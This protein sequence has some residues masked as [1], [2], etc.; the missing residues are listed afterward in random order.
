[1]S[2]NEGQSAFERLLGALDPD[3]ERAGKL[4]ERL[5]EKLATFFDWRGTSS[6]EDLA[7]KTIDRTGRKIEA[8]EVIRSADV[9]RYAYG[10]A[11]NIFRENWNEKKREVVSLRRLP[12]EP[13]AERR[14]GLRVAVEPGER[15]FACLKKCLGTLSPPSRELILRCYEGEGSAKIAR[16]K[17]LAETLGMPVGVLRTRAFRLRARLESCV[18]KCLGKDR[19]GEMI[20]G[21]GHKGRGVVS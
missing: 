13:T 8:G 5:R 4:Y 15:R 1:M 9:M 11:K 17:V 2:S 12:Q 18:T 10:V 16:R 7:D 21:S 14:T 20:S 3:R 6:P 19:K